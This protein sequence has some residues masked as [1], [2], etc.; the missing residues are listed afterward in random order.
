MDINKK[1]ITSFKKNAHRNAIIYK[2]RKITYYDLYKKTS[3]II[4]KLD[5]NKCQKILIICQNNI[6]YYEIILASLVSSTTYVP[7]SSFYDIKKKINIINESKSSLIYADDFNYKKILENRTKINNKIK[8]IYNFEKNIICKI[9]TR[10]IIDK[11]VLREQKNENENHI[12]IMYTS[13]STGK[14]KAVPISKNN[15]KAYIKNISKFIK[16]KTSDISSANFD[17]G[18]DLSV[19]DIFL[20]WLSGACLCIPT[21]L[22]YLNM[23]KFINLNK[24][25][26]WFSVPSLVSQMYKFKQLRKNEFESIRISLFCGE[27]LLNFQLKN[28]IEACKNSKIYNLYGPTETTIAISLYEIKKNSINSK[29][30][31]VIPIGKIFNDH[32]FSLIDDS[33]EKQKD[34]G[35]LI[36]SGPQ[37][38]NGYLNNKLENKKKFI[39]LNLNDW[40]CTGDKVKI[41]R[42]TLKYLGRVDRQLKINGIRIEAQEI[43][44]KLRA[45][46]ANSEV[47]ILNIHVDLNVT[48]QKKLVLFINDVFKKNDNQINN[49]ILN[50]LPKFCI[51]NKII[52]LNKFPINKNGKID[53]KKL[54]DYAK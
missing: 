35:E 25:T 48:M 1:L 22:D 14:P 45:F 29:K 38:S 13:G 7:I 15:L 10:K 17:I 44:N 11:I 42:G 51:P 49:F 8:F 6:D 20:T 54:E 47:I 3:K 9:N 23:R 50:N 53:H 4:E 16:I 19:H 36:I 40:Y 33:G 18:F 31:N 34:S 39:K 28:W 30:N 2:G 27:P 21:K 41:S 43:E 26:V 24:I 5:L 37:V 46:I 52:R 12:Y 32:K